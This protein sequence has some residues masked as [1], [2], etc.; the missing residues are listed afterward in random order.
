MGL[1]A[2]SAFWNPR[3]YDPLTPTLTKQL[4]YVNEGQILD[5]V[6][7]LAWLAMTTGLRKKQKEGEQKRKKRKI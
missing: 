4:L 1:K 7:T 5:E 6:R 3:H 2:A